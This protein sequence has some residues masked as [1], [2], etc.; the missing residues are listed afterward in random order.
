M[1]LSRIVF[2]DLQIL[3][4]LVKTNTRIV[5]HL[6]KVFAII[7]PCRT[8]LISLLGKHTRTHTQ[9]LLELSACV[10][11]LQI[12]FLKIFYLFIYK[13]SNILLKH[14]WLTCCCWLKSNVATEFITILF[15]FAVLNREIN[16]GKKRKFKLL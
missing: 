6:L 7:F 13:L 9:T 1:P 4:A 16:S 14:L 8:L 12:R 11:M 10:S 15:S 5:T 2:F 3:C